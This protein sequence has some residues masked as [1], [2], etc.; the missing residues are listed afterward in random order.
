MVLNAGINEGDKSKCAEDKGKRGLL[1]EP[2]DSLL[3]LGC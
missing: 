3:F 1:L 2:T